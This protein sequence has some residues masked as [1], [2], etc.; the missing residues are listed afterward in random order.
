LKTINFIFGIHDHQPVGNFDF[1]IE[2]AYQ[3][4]YLP[5][6]E[7][8]EEFTGLHISFHFSGCL[9]EWF[10]KHHPDFIDRIAHLVKRGNVEIISGGFYE[11][12]LAMIPDKDKVG[13]IKM[14]NSYIKKEFSYNPRGLWLTER[15][16]EPH[17]AKIISE[18]GIKYVT[19]DDYHF[20]STGKQEADLNRVKYFRFF[21]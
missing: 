19:V 12:V 8:V 20:L 14:M 15:V 6:V 18:S 7:I 10:E 9:L 13:Q 2:D 5:F 11:P 4:S 21:R 16:W 17:L 3:Q 1:V